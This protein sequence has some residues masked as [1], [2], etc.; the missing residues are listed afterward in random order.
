M[1][2]VLTGFLLWSALCISPA[3]GQETDTADE[4]TNY[5]VDLRDAARHYVTVTAEIPSGEESTT[6]MLPVWTPGSYLVREYAKQIVEISAADRRGNPLEILKTTKN[7][8]VVSN[9]KKQKQVRI[10]YRVYCREKSVRTNWADDQYALLMGAATYLVRPDR[11]ESPAVVSLELPRNWRR[12]ATSLR[13]ESTR[14]HQYRAET[15]HELVDSPIVAGKIDVYPFEVD[16]ITHALVNVNDHGAWDGSRAVRD[17]EKMVIAHHQ[18]WQRVPYDRY[19][20]LNIIGS[21]GGGGLEHDNCCVLEADQWT[22]SNPGSYRGWLSLCSHEF[23]H[24]WNVRRLRP[25]E[26]VA[27]DYENENYTPSLW[28]A[29]G[30]TSYYQ[31]L[32]LVR[33]GLSDESAMMGELTGLI[34]SVQSTPGRLKQSLRDSSHDTWIKFY[35]PGET[36]R[37]AEISYYTKG[38]VVG[39]LLDM[40]IRRATGGQKSLD[41]AMRLLYRRFAGSRGYTAADFEAICST[42]AGSDL[43]EFFQR[44]VNSTDELDYQTASTWLGMNI[45]TFQPASERKPA[46]GRESEKSGDDAG[47]PQAG[48]E[49]GEAAPPAARATATRRSRRPAGQQWSGVSAR[50]TDGRLV[51]ASVAPDSPGDAAGLSIDDEILAVNDL[52]LEGD[53]DSRLQEYPVG[54]EVELLIARDQRVFAVTLE[55]GERQF[56]FWGLS[57]SGADNS[58]RQER[59]AAWLQGTVPEPA[60]QT[61]EESGSGG[62]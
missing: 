51:V 12:S 61:R 20:F 34:N 36:T 23:F 21:S 49:A 4:V 44:S 33:A 58:A 17:L 47:N 6:V 41:D 43:S 2:R 25:K 29:E 62:D 45:G 31:D 39:W 59:R 35:R 40:E 1:L 54:E 56:E 52:R 22:C 8:W 53:L 38:A 27:Y 46:A 3:I 10:T 55:V 5:Q 57:V 60:A 50:Q 15:Y 13:S 7:R 37:T 11:L 9:P 26:L 32:L 48:A 28:V 14:P 18:M 19:L 16:G 42:V 24:T 30:I